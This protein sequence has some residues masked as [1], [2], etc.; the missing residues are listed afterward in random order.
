[1]TEEELN[2]KETQ[3]Q[4][5]LNRIAEMEAEINA[6]KGTIKAHNE[7]RGVKQTELTRCQVA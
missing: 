2:T 4:Q 6:I 7:F 5:R 1:M 3:L